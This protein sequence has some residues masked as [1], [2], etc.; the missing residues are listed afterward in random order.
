MNIITLKI[1]TTQRKHDKKTK[2]YPRTS[3]KQP[4]TRK[5]VVIT[6]HGNFSENAT[7]NACDKDLLSN[8]YKKANNLHQK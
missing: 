8:N 4:F 1:S 6:H 3:Y 7:K 2:K 5:E